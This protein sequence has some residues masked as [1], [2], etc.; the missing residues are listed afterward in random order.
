MR[1]RKKTEKLYVSEH[2][3]CFSLYVLMYFRGRKMSKFFA[4]LEG[5][6][7][8]KS[9]ACKVGRKYAILEG[10]KNVDFDVK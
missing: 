4:F 3:F 8:I 7:R 1:K 5:E 10:V 2:I 6:N 9:I